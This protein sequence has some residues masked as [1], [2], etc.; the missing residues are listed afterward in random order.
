MT[1]I[2]FLKDGVVGNV[3]PRHHNVKYIDYPEGSHFGILD[4][5]SSCNNNKL[6]VEDWVANHDKMTREFTIM[7]QKISELLTLS[8]NCLETMRDDFEDQYN[9]LF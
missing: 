7:T 8:L 5:F 4:I 3:L 2:Y 6:E 9:T 1:C